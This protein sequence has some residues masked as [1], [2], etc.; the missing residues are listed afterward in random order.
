MS[1]RSADGGPPRLPGSIRPSRPCP[2]CGGSNLWINGDLNPKFVA[3]RTCWAFGPNAPTIIQAVEHWD[4]RATK[5]AET[6]VPTP[7]RPGAP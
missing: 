5:P 1:H 7:A 4:S 3:C 6:D 2:F